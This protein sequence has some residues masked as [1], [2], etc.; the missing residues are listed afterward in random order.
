MQTVTDILNRLEGVERTAL[1]SPDEW[2]ATCPR[3]HHDSLDIGTW[4]WDESYLDDGPTD[5]GIQNAG[6][7]WIRCLYCHK[8]GAEIL[9][10]MGLPPDAAL[11]FDVAWEAWFNQLNAR[12]FGYSLGPDIPPVHVPDAEHM[13]FTEFVV[14]REKLEAER[15]RASSRERILS[16]VRA[17]MR[18]AQ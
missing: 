8:E 7:P 14:A 12:N 9:A 1:T 10:V 18:G 13:D 16:K 15:D 3:C 17:H 11:D 6:R 5:F 4:D 2:R